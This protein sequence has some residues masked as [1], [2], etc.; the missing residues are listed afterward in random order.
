MPDNSLS[1][2]RLTVQTEKG[3]IVITPSGDIDLNGSPALR[4][5]LKKHNV[6][7]SRLVVDL[8]GVPYMDSS[9]LATLVE[10]MQASRKNGWTLV[11][12]ALTDRVRSI[13]AIAKLDSVFT[14]VP[15]KADALG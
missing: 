10:A 15:T 8:T 12:C 5:E 11:L 6:K 7:G 4:A 13:F 2:L 9:G 1:S 14:I 3:A